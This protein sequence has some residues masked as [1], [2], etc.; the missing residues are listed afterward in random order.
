ME[1]GDGGEGGVGGDGGDGGVG[2]APQ[3]A[4]I[5]PSSAGQ[6]LPAS[7]AHPPLALQAAD[8]GVGGDGGDGELD[9]VVA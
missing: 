7:P 6:Q 5:V 4:S 3:Q 9:G 1:L 2:L 8:E